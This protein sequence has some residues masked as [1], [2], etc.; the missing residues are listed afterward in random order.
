[1]PLT[2]AQEQKLLA[3]VRSVTDRM[4]AMDLIV[5]AARLGEEMITVFQCGHSGM[6]FPGDYV[7]NWGKFYGIGLGP[8]PVS[9]CLDSEYDTPIPRITPDIR[10]IEQIMHPLTITFAQV[11]FDVVPVSLFEENA[12]ILA[13]DDPH[14]VERA[15]LI[16]KKQLA[17][18][19]SQLTKF[20]GMSLSEVMWTQERK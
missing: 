17:N 3:D 18:P 5:K 10:S 19:R 20:K 12:L 1:M 8:H 9:E 16:R 14:L 6:F 4:D 15:T 2:E 13:K 11:D 7:R